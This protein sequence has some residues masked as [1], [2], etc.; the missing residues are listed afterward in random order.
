MP[1]FGLKF[2][3]GDKIWEGDLTGWVLDG[4]CKVRVFNSGQILIQS[5]KCSTSG[6]Y[7]AK[8]TIFFSSLCRKRNIDLVKS[9]IPEILGYNDLSL[10]SVGCIWQQ[11]QPPTHQSRDGMHSLTQHSLW[12]NLVLTGHDKSAT[13][14]HVN[15]LF[16]APFLKNGVLASNHIGKLSGWDPGSQDRSHLCCLL[17]G[18]N[19]SESSGLV[20]NG[21]SWHFLDV[22]GTLAHYQNK[23]I[24]NIYIPLTCLYSYLRDPK[25]S[26][27]RQEIIQMDLSLYEIVMRLLRWTLYW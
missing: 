17:C 21:P 4:S 27:V 14:I 19:N 23:A 2:E 8:W 1:I 20:L 3:H 12:L 11:S 6:T 16:P 9:P 5:K 13:W 26:D 24:K 7:L 22:K 25:H 10:N 15:E 18:T